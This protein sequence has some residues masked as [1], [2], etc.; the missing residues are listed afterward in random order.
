M[1]RRSPGLCRGLFLAVLAGAAFRHRR[2]M[3]H[4]SQRTL[5]TVGVGGHRAHLDALAR[6]IEQAI[7]QRLAGERIEHAHVN[8]ARH[9]DSSVN[10]LEREGLLI[11]LKAP[12]RRAAW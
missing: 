6:L 12:T 2:R 5:Q 10:T 4:G 7:V 8:L 11:T 1:A 3:D 9:G